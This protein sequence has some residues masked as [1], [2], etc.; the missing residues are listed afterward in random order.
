[1]GEDGCG[2]LGNS[3]LYVS[4]AERVVRIRVVVELFFSLG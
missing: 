2:L 3:M 4:I 1:M